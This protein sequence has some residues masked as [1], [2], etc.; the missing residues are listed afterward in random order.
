MTGAPGAGCQFRAV[1]RDQVGQV[2]RR[3][4]A[5]EA[6]AANSGVATSIRA[7]E[8]AT[9][10]ASSGPVSM[11]D[12][13]TATAPQR[14]A[15]RIPASSSGRSEQTNITRSPGRTSAARS[16]AAKAAARSRSPA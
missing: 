9:I 11:V 13:G 7:P 1:H 14:Q 12:T 15:P 8:S 3:R 4:A 6:T 5:C 2:R 16:P 10:L